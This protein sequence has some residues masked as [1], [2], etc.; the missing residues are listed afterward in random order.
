MKKFLFFFAALLFFY[1]YNLSAQPDQGGRP[2]S[3]RTPL[4]LNF[5]TLSLAPP[6]MQQIRT[7]DEQDEKNGVLRKVGR[8]VPVN[9]N[10]LN[11]GTWTELPGGDRVWRLRITATGALALGVYYDKFWLPAGAR[12]YLYN[13]E[14]TQ[15]IGAFTEENNPG[16][17]L[18]ATQLIEGDAVT[19]ELF[20]PSRARGFS[21]I[22]ISEI[23]YVYRD[24]VY[25]KG[26]KDFG[27]S[28]SCEVN[29]NCPEGNSWQDEKKGVAR[30][31]LKIGS[32]YG[33]CSGSLLNNCRQ[34]C[35]PYF[36][37]AD[38]CGQGAST[39]DLN[40]WVFHFNYEAPACSNPSSQPASN[41]ITGCTLKANGGNG[42]NSGSDFFL[43]EFNTAPTFNPYFNGWNRNNTPAACCKPSGEFSHRVQCQCV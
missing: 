38:H 32:S 40:Q 26:L 24:F 19:L 42:G 37:T 20:E 41:T 6:D 43:V 4:D 8:S 33:W 12:L 5:E 17:G 11:A 1:T 21:E 3:F 23:A 9:S 34:D 25:R 13:D 2:L 22:S 10:L 35:T 14:K 16:S 15:L 36:L 27:D 39:A 7:E 28:E 30:I 18:F 29:I 31:F